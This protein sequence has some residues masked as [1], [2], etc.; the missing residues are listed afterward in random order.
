MNINNELIASLADKCKENYAIPAEAFA[1]ELVKRADFGMRTGRKFLWGSMKLG[2]PSP[3]FRP[4]KHRIL[5][6]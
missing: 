2:F 4:Y 5:Q 1:N 3:P 6:T